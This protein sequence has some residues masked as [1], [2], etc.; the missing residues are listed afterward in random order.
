M[1]S[2]FR[3]IAHTSTR[4]R[5]NRSFAAASVKESVSFK[6]DAV[7]DLLNRHVR[8]LRVVQNRVHERARLRSAASVLVDS[9]VKSVYHVSVVRR[10]VFPR[11]HSSLKTTQRLRSFGKRLDTMDNCKTGLDCLL[12]VANNLLNIISSN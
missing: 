8:L 5:I 6:Y 4:C 10:Y 7:Q 12:Y 11:G 1:F 9:E 3:S 2:L